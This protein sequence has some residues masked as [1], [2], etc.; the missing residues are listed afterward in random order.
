[1]TLLVAN[2]PRFNEFLMLY[3]DDGVIR[4]R[5]FAEHL[6]HRRLFWEKIRKSGLK[7]KLQKTLFCREEFRVLGFILTTNGVRPDPERMRAIYDIPAPR[8]RKD[9]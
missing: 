1:M 2:D 4:S 6:T 9:L 5:T 8:T 7:L 3:V